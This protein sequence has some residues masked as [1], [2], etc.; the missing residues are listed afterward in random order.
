MQLVERSKFV[1]R[2]GCEPPVPTWKKKDWARDVL[3]AGD[4]ATES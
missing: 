4:P 3:P 1:P 2:D